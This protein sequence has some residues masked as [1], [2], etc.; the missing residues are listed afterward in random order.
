MYGLGLR[1]YLSR[2][3]RVPFTLKCLH[4]LA[5]EL[6]RIAYTGLALEGKVMIMHTSC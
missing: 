1:F 3:E 4:G 5:L 2:V 6:E